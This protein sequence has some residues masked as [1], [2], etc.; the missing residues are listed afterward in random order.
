MPASGSTRAASPAFDDPKAKDYDGG[1][2]R[3][4]PPSA[5]TSICSMPT[6]ARAL[7]SLAFFPRMWTSRR[8]CRA[9]VGR[10]RRPRRVCDRGPAAE[11]YDLSLLLD[12]DLDRRTFRFH[13][14]TRHFLQ[15]QAGKDGLVAQHKRL[16]QRH[17]RHGRRGGSATPRTRLL[18]PLP[19]RSIW[20]APKTARRSTQLLLDPGWLKRQAR[21][22]REAHWHWWPTTK[23]LARGGCRPSS[24]RPYD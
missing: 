23:D 11:L 20:P 21:R 18:L 9:A 10:D 12:L 22:R 6:S 15:D 3:S 7:A 8:H 1:T 5:S 19:A 4:P 17:G 16:I 13:D 14:T 24:V 2:R